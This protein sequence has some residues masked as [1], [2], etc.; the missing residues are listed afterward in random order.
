MFPWVHFK[1][2]VMALIQWHEQLEV[3]SSKLVATKKWIKSH[4]K[5]KTK[6]KRIGTGPEW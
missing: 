2:M 3:Q 6:K 1:Q 5:T 4:L